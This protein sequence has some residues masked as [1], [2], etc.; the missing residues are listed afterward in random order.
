M[1]QTDRTGPTNQPGARLQTFKAAG[2]TI[3]YPADWQ[4]FDPSQV[5][6]YRPALECLLVAGDPADG[7]NLVLARLFQEHTASAEE[8]DR[9]IWMDA[10][11]DDADLR[12]ES[13]RVVRV[14]GMNAVER[15]FSRLAARS[16]RERTYNLQIHTVVGCTIYF[17]YFTALSAEALAAHQ[18]DIAS[19]VASITIEP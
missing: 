6:R 9:V 19:T 16:S 13:Y 4:T 3:A 18:E 5:G 1:R 7:T 2:I 11:R 8:V 10:K 17:I 15:L 14:S 12:L